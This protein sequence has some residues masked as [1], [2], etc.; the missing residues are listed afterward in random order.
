MTVPIFTAYA[1]G[2]PIGQ[3]TLST[4]VNRKTGKQHSFWSNED[5]LKPWRNNVAMA[6]T[7]ALPEAYEP[8]SGPVGLNLVFISP[9]AKS[10]P[11]VEAAYKITPYDLDK[12]CRA[13]FD[14]LTGV[15]YVDDRQVA[16]LHAI[17]VYT[18]VYPDAPDEGLIFRAHR[19]SGIE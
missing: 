7:M 3:G 9:R 1:K 16:Q 13:V 2:K 6:A 4:I 11:S 17:K 10:G 12:L 8:T 15:V 18:D 14:A 19:L 5:E